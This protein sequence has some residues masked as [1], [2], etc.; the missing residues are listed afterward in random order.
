MHVIDWAA[1]QKEDP[2][3]DAVLQRLESK[4]K[5]DLRTLL[6]EYAL[7]E[8]GQMVWYGEI[9]KISLPFEVPLTYTPPQRGA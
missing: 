7:S 3:L 5:T 8:E 1:A 2:K 4:K 9:I 6:R